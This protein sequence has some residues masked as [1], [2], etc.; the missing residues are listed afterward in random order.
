[1]RPKVTTLLAAVVIV[2]GLAFTVVVSL[3]R[4]ERG[5]ET[6]RNPLGVTT[7]TSSTTTTVEP[8]TVVTMPLEVP[9]ETE[10]EPPIRTSELFVSP[11]GLDR[12]D[13]GWNREDPLATPSYAAS[14]AVPGDTI[15]ILPGTYEPLVVSSKQDLVFHAP[16]G[17][18]TLTSGTYERDAGVLI[19]KSSG[20][21]VEGLRVERSLWGIR[22]F[23]SNGVVVRENTVL[24]IGQEAIHI[25]SRSTDVTVEGN[26]VNSTGQRPGSN[27]EFEYAD[28]GEGIYLGT[29]GKLSDGQIDIVSNVRIIGNDIS[30]TSAEAIEIKAS[31]F[32]V[33]VRNNLVHDIDVHSGAAVSIGRGVRTY[34]ANV[35]V[36]NNA[37]WNITTRNQWDD[38]IGIRVSSTAD[39]SANVIWN[40][41][42]Y[43][44]KIDDELRHLDGVVDIRNNLIFDAG[45]SAFS[46]DAGESGVPITVEGTIEDSEAEELLGQLGQ[47]RSG[48]SP[49]VLID[50]LNDL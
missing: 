23:S 32:D 41:Q 3:N 25:L 43:G 27:G 12:A 35:L 17:G 1:M 20:I 48:I 39:V 11:S 5:V 4:T 31:V 22:V 26:V 21:V 16:E 29:G 45:I 33:I 2:A 24:D 14:I 9:V 37:I 42:H 47:L 6:Y 28:L 19:E 50:Y 18:V 44:I 7:T 38:G 10:P 30:N 15:N 36:E 34:D 13:G 40:V 46:N 49:M 8:S